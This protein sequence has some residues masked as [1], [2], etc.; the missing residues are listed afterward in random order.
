MTL[1]SQAHCVEE[2]KQR[3]HERIQH[4][5]RKTGRSVPLAWTS[6]DNQVINA[7]AHGAGDLLPFVGFFRAFFLIITPA[8]CLLLFLLSLVRI[9]A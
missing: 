4:G 7:F 5:E 3:R 2:S 8:V 1:G 9:H 6:A